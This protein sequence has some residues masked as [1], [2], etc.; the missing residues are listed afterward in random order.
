VVLDENSWQ[1]TWRMWL[2]AFVALV[3]SWWYAADDQPERFEVSL[4]KTARS[5]PDN[6]EPLLTVVMQTGARWWCLLLIAFAAGMARFRLALALFVA[7]A[8]SW[9]LATLLKHLVTS[10]RPTA[11]A[12]DKAPRIAESGYGFPSTHAA[13]S[14][15]VML[16]LAA[17]L[18]SSR[19]GRSSVG[20]LLMIGCIACAAVTALARMYLGAHWLFDVIGGAALGVM[21]GGVGALIG[22]RRRSAVSEQWV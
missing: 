11:A 13:M 18:R 7:G 8:S 9:L 6:L 22:R 10:P 1:L 16:T 5:L 15:A 2:L 3:V 17:V 12:L 20:R 14:A 21:C 19:L 4:G